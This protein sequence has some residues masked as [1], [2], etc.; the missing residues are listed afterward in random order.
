MQQKRRSDIGSW[1]SWLI[2]LLLIF[3]SRFLPPVANW[4]TQTTGLPI[5]TPML[6]GAL[7]MLSIAV[8]LI[9]SVAR[10]GEQPRE[11]LERPPTPPSS[12]PDLPTT[13]S[14]FPPP[15]VEATG[16]LRDLGPQSVPQP[17][18]FEP[19]MS[20]RMLLVGIIGLVFIGLFLFLAMLIVGTP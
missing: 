10:R 16:R 20:P 2:F 19:I 3:G 8:S 11:P 13:S 7:V 18:R 14:P 9:G 4:L 17:P 5:T 12:R 15:S 6:I 1:L